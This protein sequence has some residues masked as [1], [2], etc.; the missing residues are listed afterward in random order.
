MRPACASSAER[1]VAGAAL[2]PLLALARHDEQRVVDR[3]P[4]AESRDE[5]ERE[6]R[7]GMNLDAIRSPRNVSAIAPSPSSGGRNAATSPRKTQKESRSTSGKAISSARRRSSWI[8]SV[9]CCDAIAPPPSRTSGSPANADDRRAAASFVASPPFAW[10]YTSTTPRS[11]MTVRA[12]AGSPPILRVHARYRAGAAADEREHTGVGLD[13][14]LPRSTSRFARR[15]SD[16]RSANWVDP[17][18][19]RGITVLPSASAAAK[20]QAEKSVTARARV[21]IRRAKERT[22]RKDA[23]SRLTTA[24]A[25]VVSRA[26]R[27]RLQGR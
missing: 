16:E 21:M 14:G 11:S 3:E 13:A 2:S 10:R 19:M 15:L 26:R 1:L 20:T 18:S 22:G 5:V 17:A 12:T 4:E 9:T 27:A 25:E 6:D 8:A 24:Q 7:E 23:P